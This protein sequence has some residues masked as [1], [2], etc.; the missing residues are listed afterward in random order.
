MLYFDKILLSHFVSKCFA[1]P[2]PLVGKLEIKEKLGHKYIKLQYVNESMYIVY[3][4]TNLVEK[5]YFLLLRF[6]V[7]AENH[8]GTLSYHLFA[9]SVPL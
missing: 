3:I 4:V 6:W 5:S 8:T 1:F 2:L 7:V 9:P